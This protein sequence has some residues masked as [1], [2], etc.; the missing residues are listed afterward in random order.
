M[1]IRAPPQ[2]P[3]IAV[4]P[5]CRAFRADPISITLYGQYTDTFEEVDGRWRFSDR[6]IT[7]DLTGQGSARAGS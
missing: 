7:T 3:P 1:S 6:L 5:W 2:P 4:G